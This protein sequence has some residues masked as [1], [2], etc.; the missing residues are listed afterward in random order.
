MK[1]ALFTLATTTALFAGMSYS[2]AAM[3]QSTGTIPVGDGEWAAVSGEIASVADERFMLDHGDGLLTV[4]MDDFLPLDE[5][6]PLD[7][8]S[9]VTVY[10]E[11]DNDL[12]EAR[13]IEA[14]SVY[15]EARN[16][17]YYASSADEEESFPTYD[18]AV[19]TAPAETS[20]V[21]VS[22]TVSSVDGR[23]VTLEVG[24]TTMTVDTT[25]LDYNPTDDIGYPSVEKGD[26]IQVSGDLTDSFFTDQ[27]VAANMLTV[28]DETSGT[29]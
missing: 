4:E 27:T 15:S 7:V 2:G 19:M 9:Q 21:T 20:G 3:A 28:L 12:Y 18:V 1:N 22:G 23:E 10:G 13:K 16:T 26:R 17:Y 14:S 6:A 8:G 24:K 11:V 29:S 5:T 25:S